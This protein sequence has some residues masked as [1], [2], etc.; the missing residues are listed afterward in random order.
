MSP[1]LLLVN[2]KT[3]STNITIKHHIGYTKSKERLLVAER[4]EA[5]LV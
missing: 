3:F 2:T 4:G 5:L 1:P